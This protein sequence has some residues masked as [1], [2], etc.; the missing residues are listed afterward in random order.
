MSSIRIHE[1][2]LIVDDDKEICNFISEIFN[3]KGYPTLVTGSGIEAM[4]LIKDEK[5]FI[6]ISDLI[7]P[8]MNGIELL[9]KI[10]K[11]HPE[12]EVIIM[13][14][15]S[16]IETAVEA[17]K[18]GAFDYILKPLSSDHLL[19]LI[20]RIFQKIKLL[21]ENIYLL[22]ELSKKYHFDNIIG[23]SLQMIKLYDEIKRA[24]KTDATVLL[25]GE[26]GTGKELVASAIHYSSQRK[27]KP[28][29]KLSC[30]ALSEGIIESELFGHEKGAFTSALYSKKGRFEL[31]DEGTLF[32][33]E[34]GDLPPSTQVKLLRVLENKEFERVGGT[35]TIK[36]NIRLIS[37]TN[38]NLEKMIAVKKFREDLFYRLNVVSLYI[39]PLR[40][41]KSDIELLA[42]HF[43]HKYSIETN[44]RIYGI[45]KKAMALLKDY[46]WIGNVREL[47]N[48]IERAVVFCQDN[49]IKQEHLPNH[50]T[51]SS[52][53][54]GISLDIHSKSL[55][56][57]EKTLI[58]NVIDETNGNMKKAS[59]ILGISRGTLYS[60]ME[61]LG[62]RKS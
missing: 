22:E 36:V 32:L 34:I 16:T 59:D 44:K 4:E 43:L 11:E 24:S 56:L 10:K 39:P 41:R 8:E 33:D 40:E 42:D 19:L 37:A 27:G 20:D 58:K 54:K 5:V 45:S 23:Q 2:I 31:A 18:V 25:T 47:E 21:N 7:M 48:A 14:A 1:K 35:Q 46:S 50:I 17:M 51:K 6:V 3:I 38:Q 57:V 49:I 29:V 13:T 28:F 53:S 9:K 62:I 26:S 15:Y 55:A 60:K 52:D 12:I 61:K 30:A